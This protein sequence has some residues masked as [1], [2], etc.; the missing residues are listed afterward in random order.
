MKVRWLIILALPLGGCVSAVR[1]VVTAPFKA[2]GQAADWATTSQDEADRDRGR[3][4]R[5]AEAVAR[6]D[7]RRET[8]GAYD[9]ARCVRARMT[10]EGY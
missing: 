10:G 6:K 4:I 2:V 5:R 9:Q 1:S 8:A 7:C 3:K